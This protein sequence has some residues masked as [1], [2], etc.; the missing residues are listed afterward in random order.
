[1]AEQS[2]ITAY[3]HRVFLAIY[4]SEYEVLAWDAHDAFYYGVFDPIEVYYRIQQEG[5]S[6][7][8]EKLLSMKE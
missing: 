4:D 1:M 7:F 8:I 2:R 3:T 5:L 6:L